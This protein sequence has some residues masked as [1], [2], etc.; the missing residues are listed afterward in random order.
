MTERTYKPK[1]APGFDEWMRSGK[2][3]ASKEIEFGQWWRFGRSYWR[4]SWIQETNE[5]YAVERGESDRFVLLTELDR[6]AVNE[7]M[8]KWFDGDNLEALL[9]RFGVPVRQA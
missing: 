5:L 3:A 4:V 1:I 6:N 8:K 7:L 9:H 2:R